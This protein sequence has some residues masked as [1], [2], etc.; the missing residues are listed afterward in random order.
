MYEP[1]DEPPALTPRE[2]QVFELLRRGFEDHRIAQVLGITEAEAHR[3]VSEVVRKLG[4]TDDDLAAWQPERAAGKAPDGAGKRRILGSRA[5]RIAGGVAAAVVAVIIAVIG[6]S[7][8]LD[9][10]GTVRAPEDGDPTARWPTRGDH[11]HAALDIWIC[12]EA[13]DAVPGFPGGVHT[14]SD[15]F[16]HIHP[17]EPDE[18]GPGASLSRFF[19]Y[20][21]GALTHDRL[22]VPGS[23][24]VHNI[25]DTCPDGTPGTI[26]VW[27]NGQRIDDFPVYIPQDGDDIIVAFGPS[28]EPIPQTPRPI[29]R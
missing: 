6:L 8:L 26:K 4:I 2:W 18:E 1:R 5:A 13:Q 10:D 7:L 29:E 17:M 3:H 12:G 27:V 15:G 11:W 14:H 21:G 22:Q 24:S 28:A 25:G 19:E 20:G 9:D 16:I 23:S